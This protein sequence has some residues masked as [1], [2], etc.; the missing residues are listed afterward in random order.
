MIAIKFSLT[1][2]AVLLAST[3]AAPTELVV[4]DKRATQV[5][6]DGSSA[7]VGNL[8]DWSLIFRASGS[9]NFYVTLQI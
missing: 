5:L 1:S 8:P 4:L 6:A 3:Y 2:L 9:V 7:V